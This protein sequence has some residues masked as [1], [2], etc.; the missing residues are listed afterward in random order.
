MIDTLRKR[1]LPVVRGG[2]APWTYVED[3]ATAT[4]ADR[5]GEAYNICDDGAASWLDVITEPA[6][7]FDAPKPM[8]VA[9]WC[10]SWRR[11]PVVRGGGESSPRHLEEAKSARRAAPTLF[12]RVS[13]VTNPANRAR[14]PLIE[15]FIKNGNDG[16]GE[17]S[18]AGHIR[19][20]T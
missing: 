8:V 17:S 3:A 18:P 5:G 4:A 15:E 6:R 12:R 1:R 2:V 11:T 13:Y 14:P 19:H 9:R 10:A 16:A 20:R 7:V